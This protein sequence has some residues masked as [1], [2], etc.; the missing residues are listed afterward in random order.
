ME[1]V[2]VSAR[3][4]EAAVE[5]A[6]D[7]LG[8]HD[9]EL[10]YEVV[11]EPKK[12]VLG[13]GRTEA[14]IRAR[15]KPVSREK[16]N[17]RRRRR[18]RDERKPKGEGGQK[19]RSEGQA[20]GDSSAKQGQKQGQKQQSAP[21][22]PAAQSA[23]S[24]DAGAA[25][26][27]EAGGN[28]SRNRRR[29][30]RGGGEGAA[31]S[32]GT[33]AAA[34][35]DAAST[36]VASDATAT[37]TTPTPAERKARPEREA[38]AMTTGSITEQLDAAR[39]F[40]EGF[41]DAFGVEGSVDVTNVDDEAIEVS[42]TGQNLGLLLGP[43]G[44]TLGAIEELLRGSVGHRGPARVH[45]DIAGYRARRKA[46]L[47]DFARTVAQQVLDSGSAKA[48]EPMGSADRK[49]VHDTVAEIDGV[50]TISDGEDTRRRVVI[51]PA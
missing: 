25:S 16:P 3:T 6:L 13:F 1:W 15:I 23:D 35:T 42:I 19:P 31:A 49:V 32:Q 12:G 37:P 50:T 48:L 40:A 36:A 43:Q 22:T 34:A 7:M 9:T 5:Q 38:P 20:K 10:E 18:G 39:T 2:T 8:V 14:T 33:T 47:A 44:V 51:K 24:G 29:G 26:S 45:L 41:L 4:V 30:G 28:R 21:K 46:A 17:D 11:I 27:G